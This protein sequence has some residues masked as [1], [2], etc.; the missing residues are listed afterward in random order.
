MDNLLNFDSLKILV[1]SDFVT[2]KANQIYSAL[3]TK[4]YIVGKGKD[5]TDLYILQ[6]NVTYKLYSSDVKS[7]ILSEVTNLIV[8]SFNNLSKENQNNLSKPNIA[9]DDD[10][11]DDQGKKK[12][13][14]YTKPKIFNNSFV[15]KFYPQLF[16]LL[17][18]DEIKFDTYFNEIHF[19]NGF[20]DLKTL[21]FKQR[22]QGK[23]YI[24]KYIE[25]DYKKSTDAQKELILSHIKKT[26]P[27]KDDL[28]VILLSIGSSL[29][30]KSYI[31]QDTLF[32]LGEGSSG[33]SNILLLTQASITVYFQ[34]LQSDTFAQANSKIDKIL[35]TYQKNPQIRISWC[36]ELKDTKIDDSLFKSFIDS[37]LNA[38]ALYA[39]G[40]KS[41]KHYSKT[42]ITANTMPNIK[43]DTGVS[44]R[45][46]GYTHTSKFV[47]DPALVNE[48]NHV[49]LGNKYF[50]DDMEE[51][52][53]LDAWFDIL[54]ENCAEWNKGE[55]I[56]YSKNFESTKDEV[57]N[58]N[59][60]FLD[61]VDSRIL[62][63][64]EPTDRIGKNKMHEAFSCMYPNRK[65]TVLQIITSLKEKKLNY[66]GKLRCDSIQGCFIGVKFKTIN[67]D[68]ASDDEEVE[69]DYK[70]EYFKL[71]AK[72]NKLK[73][74]EI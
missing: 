23:H 33:K 24:T 28:K 48:K 39:D 26:Y 34:E 64:G 8:N 37:N 9:D 69:K 44:R 7:K 2:E 52:K 74:N 47:S 6:S 12:K 17:V 5:K 72:F 55:K 43:I 40:Q 42:F 49:Y 14:K 65:L 63:T 13:V 1:F 68:F 53:L 71:L 61:F 27:N 70:S 60:I 11:D 67:D 50:I 45:F 31:D 15:D 62:I 18:N 22:E 51:C 29:S 54:A 3:K 16:S 25:R 32:L 56:I 19:N 36:N 10:D 66:D 57:I 38:T 35:M 30:G 21:E 20:I 73:N 41:F 59:D 4:L 58:S 46:K